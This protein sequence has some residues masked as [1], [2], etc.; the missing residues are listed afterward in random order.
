MKDVNSIFIG[1]MA[2]QYAR[3]SDIGTSQYKKSLK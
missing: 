1:A 2:K 3:D